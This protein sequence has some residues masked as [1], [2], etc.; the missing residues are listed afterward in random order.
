MAL[1]LLARGEPFQ[2]GQIT[3]RRLD[4][5]TVEAAV[6]SSWQL[7]N[8]TE[9]RARND[10]DGARRLVALLSEEAEF[11]SAIDGS[12]IEY[13]LVKDYEIGSV[14]ICRLHDG[15]LVRTGARPT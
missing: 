11:Q 2:L 9:E 15:D 5:Q 13:V 1:E 6:A 8:V 14:E 7:D 4:P 3:F 12:T 10:L